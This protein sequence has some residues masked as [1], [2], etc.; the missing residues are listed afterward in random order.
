MKRLIFVILCAAVM[1]G[2]AKSGTPVN[3]NDSKSDFE[4]QRLFSIDG[5]VIYR[6]WDNGDPV[7]FTS[8]GETFQVKHRTTFVNSKVR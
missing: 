3:V 2:C 8:N 4:V 5:I 6:F 7:Y 1:V